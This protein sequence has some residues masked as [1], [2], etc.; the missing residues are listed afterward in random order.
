MSYWEDEDGP[1]CWCGHRNHE[2]E[3]HDLDPS[4]VAYW[5]PDCNDYCNGGRCRTCGEP[6]NNDDEGYCPQHAT[7]TE[8]DE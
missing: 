7:T 4:L 3:R 5:C 2:Q 6:L 1:D 8:D